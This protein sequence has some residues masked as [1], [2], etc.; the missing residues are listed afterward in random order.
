MKVLKMT[1]RPARPN[2]KRDDHKSGLFRPRRRAA[3]A[4]RVRPATP[5]VTL[6]ETLTDSWDHLQG[7]GG[8][9]QCIAVAIGATGVPLATSLPVRETVEHW[10][11]SRQCHPAEVFIELTRPDGR[12]WNFDFTQQGLDLVTTGSVASPGFYSAERALRFDHLGRPSRN[13][14]FSLLPEDQTL[15]IA[16]T[17]SGELR[18]SLDTGSGS[19]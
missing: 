5:A 8:L 18:W 14:L 17:T 6:L 19:P 4:Q 12:P 1:P 7:N 11:T 3:P 9:P 16:F 2:V 15:A 10:R 13:V